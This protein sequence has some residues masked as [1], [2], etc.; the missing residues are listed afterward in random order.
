MSKNLKV[1]KIKNGTVIDH[2]PAG[3]GLKI[4]EYIIEPN[5]DLITV[6]GMNFESQKMGK[7]DVIKFEGY[8]DKKQIEKI[9][10]I[11]DD[12]TINIIK[13]WEIREKYKVDSLEIYE[14]IA[15]C[16]NPMCIT[17]DPQERMGYTDIVKRDGML[18]CYYCDHPQDKKK[19]IE[20][21]V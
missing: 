10:L 11:V 19:L 3:Y 1:K 12:A 15:K 13:N 7:K 6:I 16:Q 8:L 18:Y 17:N 21:L 9:S 4:L 5:S 2:I 14:G 20:N